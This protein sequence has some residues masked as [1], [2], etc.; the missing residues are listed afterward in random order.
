MSTLPAVRTE[1][2]ELDVTRLREDDEE[3][4]LRYIEPDLSENSQRAY[5]S[6]LKEFTQW[7]RDPER[8]YSPWPANEATVIA[9]L[10]WA[11]EGGK[12]RP[13]SARAVKS[14]ISMVHDA[15]GH[16]NP[17]RGRALANALRRL[18]RLHE[19]GRV[20]QAH[21]ALADDVRTM[22]AAMGTELV[23][24]RDAALLW[25]QFG[26]AMRR[27]EVVALDVADLE[28]MPGGRVRA[29]IRRSK[30]DQTAVG[31]T[32]VLPRDAVEALDRW[33]C[34]GGISSGPIFR[35]M[36]R[37][38]VSGSRLTGQS[39]REIV[40]T[41]AAAAELRPGKWS[42][43]SP[44]RG[45]ATEAVANGASVLEL[46]R[47]GRWKSTSAAEL[48]VDDSAWTDDPERLLGLDRD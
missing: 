22:T 39:V 19:G 20:E 23:D 30:T 3:R 21:A 41:R 35:R 9:Y 38:T 36:I 33:L 25:T 24:L 15:A 45:A 42:G 43:H 4:V 37:R 34:A 26:G 16:P 31:K 13:S 29:H 1:S 7:C 47:F 44:R 14:A 17:T 28:R 32:V 46:K 40:K 5:R 18:D 11:V 12:L 8:D 10:T 6:H 2:A 48:Y 27:S